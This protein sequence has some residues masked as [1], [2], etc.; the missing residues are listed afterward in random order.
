[1]FFSALSRCSMA[2]VIDESLRAASAPDVSSKPCS[3]VRP[4]GSA[5]Q[6]SQRDLRHILARGRCSSAA[7][8]RPHYRQHHGF[9]IAR[10]QRV[11][12]TLAGVQL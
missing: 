2:L 5:A 12:E 3:A 10:R 11:V 9:D 6:G 7:A 8:V 1:M 4:R